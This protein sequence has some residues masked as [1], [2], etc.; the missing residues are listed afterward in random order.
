MHSLPA[1]MCGLLRLGHFFKTTVVVCD[2]KSV[3]YA[4]SECT[5][6]QTVTR[7]LALW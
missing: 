7:K 2:K 3:M 6:R 5:D 1:G 4:I